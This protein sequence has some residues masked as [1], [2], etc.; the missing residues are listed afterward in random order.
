MWHDNR[1]S[2]P[3]HVCGPLFLATIVVLFASTL[4]GCA[5]KTDDT[6]S[7]PPKQEPNRVAVA[8]EAL[9]SI[10][11]CTLINGL[12]DNINQYVLSGTTAQINALDCGTDRITNLY[13]NGA[14]LTSGTLSDLLMLPYVTTGAYYCA[15]AEADGASVNGT[16]GGWFGLESQFKVAIASPATTSGNFPRIV[17]RRLGTVHLFGI[18][19]KIQVQDLDWQFPFELGTGSTPPWYGEYMSVRS[20]GKGWNFDMSATF[21]VGEVLKITLHPQLHQALGTRTQT[22]NAI[23]F[24]PERSSNR[25]ASDYYYATWDSCR[26]DVS[27][28]HPVSAIPDD[29]L[30]IEHQ[31]QGCLPNIGDFGD[32][33]LPYYS[34]LGGAGGAGCYYKNAPHDFIFLDTLKNWFQFGKPSSSFVGGYGAAESEPDHVITTTD[35]VNN[36][37]GVMR[38]ATFSAA[39]TASGEFDFEFVKMLLETTATMATRDGFAVRQAHIQPVDSGSTHFARVW[40]D[41]NAQ[42][43]ADLLIHVKLDFPGLPFVPP[44]EVS[45]TVP[46]DDNHNVESRNASNQSTVPSAMEYYDRPISDGSL[47][48]RGFSHYMVRGVDKPN[49]DAARI[50][51]FLQNP[52]INRAPDEPED[53]APKLAQIA[54]GAVDYVHPCNVKTCQDTSIETDYKWSASKHQLQFE[55][56]K[57]PCS[58]CAN[59]QMNLCTTGVD[60]ATGKVVEAPI[61]RGPGLSPILIMQGILASPGANCVH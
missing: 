24:V 41:L 23:Q 35:V 36:L 58:I 33:Q 28:A 57:H 54:Q 40:T 60:P 8:Q 30:V 21:P 12:K 50:Q 56:Q 5:A 51:C 61:A 47:G 39:I 25:L 6:A 14:E 2:H 27:C 45:F 19:M 52:A 31:F 22:N 15:L 32:G 44:L 11:L 34:T 42:T 10:D 49:P 48:S 1:D 59:V 3:T 13:Y 17:A 46:I 9:G 7:S 38:D 37:S 26:Q 18:P 4:S 20:E 43:K 29:L 16:L 55:I 53:P